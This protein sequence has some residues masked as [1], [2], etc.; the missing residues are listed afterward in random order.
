MTE[1]ISDKLSER[2]NVG[3]KLAIAEAIERHRRLGEPISILKD[4][5]IVTL[6][7]DQI[8]PVNSRTKMI[9]W[10][11]TPENAFETPSCFKKDDYTLC[12]NNGKAT[13]TSTR[14]Q[15][16]DLEIIEI[17]KIVKSVFQAGTI[18]F[19]KEIQFNE[20]I[21][22]QDDKVYTSINFSNSSPELSS[23]YSLIDKDGNILADSKSDRINRDRE[24]ISDVL[25]LYN[26]DNVLERLLTSY[27]NAIKN[28]SDEFSYLYE[29]R[30]I[31]MEKY[32]NKNKMQKQLRISEKDWDRFGYITCKLPVEQSRHRG[33]HDPTKMRPAT[34]EE[35]NEVKLIARQ[36]IK[37]YLKTIT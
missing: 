6:T 36:M 4:G 10:I 23:D 33:N 19:N 13:V 11:Y 12:I 18:Q 3:V 17:K 9:E 37:A 30:E 29:I 5:Q 14:P 25:N 32:N 31:L 35:L 8:P 34:T 27:S 15:I 16:D 1:P 24:F 20:D 28:P 22:Y 7:A 21:Y 26:E 2:I